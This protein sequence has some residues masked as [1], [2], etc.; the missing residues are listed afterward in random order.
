M[1]ALSIAQLHDEIAQD[2]PFLL[3]LLER[4]VNI[5]SH[6]A[7]FAGCNKVVDCLQEE[8]Q[9]LGLSC[10]RK[11]IAI[12]ADILHARSAARHSPYT[13]LVGHVDT[14]HAEA[15]PFQKY[16]RS[17]DSATG[18]GI[19]DMKGGLVILLGALRAL[20]RQQ[21]LTK[22]P[23]S[24]L[25]NSDEE[26]GSPASTSHINAEC[27]GAKQALVFEWGREN[28][29]LILQR[30]GLFEAEVISHGKAA[31]SGNAHSKGISAIVE[32]AQHVIGLAKLT[33]YERALTCNVGRITGGTTL[34]TVPAEASALFQ[35]RASKKSDLLGAIDLAKA[36]ISKPYLSG[37]QTEL[38]ERR[39]VEPMEKLPNSEALLELITFAGKQVG[40][41]FTEIKKPLGGLS[42]A[43]TTAAQGVPTIDGLGPLGDGAHTE[44]EHVDIASFAPRIAAVAYFLSLTTKS[45]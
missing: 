39:L 26:I 16:C 8:L 30:S 24:V 33:D 36:L 12:S 45:A 40:I 44:Q 31:H 17:G 19:L 10:E 32:L 29:G 15:S 28:N 9:G 11:A 7:N 5:N 13:L 1:S 25:L 41:E 6:S 35:L 3:A 34:N 4:L 38:R 22:I 42:N 27:K 2:M 14:V 21:Q 37:A 20:H 43:N 23:L 18:P